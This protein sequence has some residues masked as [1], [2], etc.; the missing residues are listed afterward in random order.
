MFV[1]MKM[2]WTI[3]LRVDITFE[4][5]IYK[6][7]LQVKIIY[8]FLFLKQVII[9][10]KSKH[11]FSIIVTILFNI[12]YPYILNVEI[13]GLYYS[14][15]WSCVIPL[16]IRRCYIS[17]ANTTIDLVQK[18]MHIFYKYEYLIWTIKQLLLRDWVVHLQHTLHES[19]ILKYVLLI[20]LV[21]VSLSSMKSFRHDICSFNGCHWHWHWRQVCLV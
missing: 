15:I 19:N 21:M 5:K 8:I 10:S 12:S 6:F 9:N 18:G 14:L 4:G 13:S 3:N 2:Y 7:K 11:L 1:Y 16:T 17:D 20:W